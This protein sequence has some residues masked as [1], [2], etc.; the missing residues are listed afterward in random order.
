MPVIIALLQRRQLPALDTDFQ[1]LKG[2]GLVAII[3]TPDVC[4]QTLALAPAGVELHRLQATTA[5]HHP[6][7]VVQEIFL[8]LGIGMHLYP[9][10]DAITASDATDDKTL[11]NGG[12]RTAPY[13]IERV[14]DR[15]GRVVFEREVARAEQ[16]ADPFLVGELNQMLT[17]V[18]ERGTGR[19][20]ALEGHRAAGKTGTNQ[21]YRDAWFVG[22]TGTHTVG[23]WVGNDDFSP[24][25]EVTGGRL[26]AEIWREVMAA[27]IGLDEEK[28]DGEEIA[29]AMPEP[30]EPGASLPEA[31]VDPFAHLGEHHIPVPDDWRSAGGGPW[32]PGG[33]YAFAYRPPGDPFANG[34]AV[35]FADLAEQGA[36][37]DAPDDP[38]PSA[39]GS[40]RQSRFGHRPGRGARLF[41]DRGTT[42]FFGRRHGRHGG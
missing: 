32:T 11:A 8:W 21:E 25:N 13:A 40:G 28:P 33:G 19:R 17:H 31:E 3:D 36:W 15:E 23:V 34:G 16:V 39:R 26:P 22:F 41:N 30:G 42:I 12:L 35:P 7:T 9:T 5:L 2:L 4:H 14:L 20:A 38:Q 37:S 10:L 18:I 29:V 27:A 6:A 24:M 1:A